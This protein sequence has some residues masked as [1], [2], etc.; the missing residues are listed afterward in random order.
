M[1]GQARPS[2]RIP[3]DEPFEWLASA[4]LRR[5]ANQSARDSSAVHL[6]DC[7]SPSRRAMAVHSVARDWNKLPDQETM[8]GCHYRCYPEVRSNPHRGGAGHGGRGDCEDGGS[9]CEA[10]AGARR[11]APRPP[12]PRPRRT[13]PT[14]RP[15]RPPRTIPRLTSRPDPEGVGDLFTRRRCHQRKWSYPSK[16]VPAIGTAASSGF[17]WLTR[18]SST[19]STSR[20]RTRRSAS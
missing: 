20:R 7:S 9:D 2:R 14:P 11:P 17:P 5:P 10:A 6:L 19:A 12:H 18:T 16:D 13:R 1:H 8:F 4:R 3:S 15:H